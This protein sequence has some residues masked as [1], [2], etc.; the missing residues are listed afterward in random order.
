MN[1]IKYI[2]TLV[3]AVIS[4]T[5]SAQYTVKVLR[6]M[7]GETAI[8]NYL[9]PADIDS[10]TFSK[11]PLY[12]IS[13]SSTHSEYG[14]QVSA[15]A[16]KV[17]AGETVELTA[18]RTDFYKFSYWSVNGVEVSRE[19]P[20]TVEVSSDVE[21][22]ANFVPDPYVAR[23]AVDMGLS[24]KWATCNLGAESPEQWGD[25]Y[26]WGE[27]FP[28]TDLGNMVDDINTYKEN[29]EVLPVT[30]DAVRTQWKGEW[31]M[32]TKE[33]CEELCDRCKFELTTYNGESVVKVTSKVNGGV[34]YFPLSPIRMYSTQLYF[35]GA[36]EGEALA[37][38][39]WYWSSTNDLTDT[40]KAYSLFVS[41]NGISQDISTIEKKWGLVIRPVIK[42]EE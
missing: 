7:S 31:R 28:R 18:Q 13:V 42:V 14:T 37:E 26:L 20:Y 29:P 25:H 19:N 4:L 39:T 38:S 32:P 36:E 5:A 23:E 3:F 30:A 8:A 12:T 15:S 22:V 10:N 17:R 27:T 16:D 6:V 33:E 2:L 40:K 41:S 35:P 11:T 1:R 24:V 21:C 34:I 9:L